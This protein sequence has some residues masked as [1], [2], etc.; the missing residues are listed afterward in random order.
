[1]NCEKCKGELK[2]FKVEV[3]DSDLNSEGFECKKCGE[4]FFNKEKSKKIVEDL[5]TKELMKNLPALSIKQKVIKLSK[6]RLGFYFNKDIIRCTNLKAGESI[7]VRLL[8]KK[9]I[10]LEI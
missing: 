10:L 9:H 2:K 4:L 8:T 6:D 3:E 5:K 7:E 1:M